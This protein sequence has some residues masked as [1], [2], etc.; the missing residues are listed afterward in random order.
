MEIF[1]SY[2]ALSEQEQIQ[3]EQIMMDDRPWYKYIIDYTLC[4]HF[5]L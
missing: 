3:I 4:F 5:T 1:I 2:K